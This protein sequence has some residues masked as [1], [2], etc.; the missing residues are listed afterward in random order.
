MSRKK[1]AD[2]SKLR[3][4][5]QENLRVECESTKDL[6]YIDSGNEVQDICTR[7]N[8]VVFARRGCGKTLLLHYSARVL[9]NDIKA[10]YLNCEDF[11][12][13]SFP[14][15]LIEIFDAIF[16]ELLKNLHGWFG[17]KKKLRQIV[18]EII[19]ELSS[20]RET[21]DIS[22]IQVTT[23]TSSEEAKKVD[24]TA[25]YNAKKFGSLE[26]GAQ[27]GANRKEDIEKNFYTKTDKLQ[28]IDLRLPWFKQK[29]R[30]FFEIS[31]NVKFIFL[32]IDDFYHLRQ[33][34]QP[35]VVDYIHRLCKDVPLFFKIATLRHVSVLYSDHKGQPIGAQERHDYQPINIDYTFED[36]QKTK[37]KN[38]QIF[39][40][41]GELAGIKSTEFDTL[42]FK[43]EGFDRLV[44]AGGG[45]PRDTLSLFLE[46]FSNVQQN[47][48]DRIGKD[49]V[50][51]LS[52]AN[53]EHLIQELKN[54]SELIEQEPL[55]K[56]IYVIRTF[57]MEKRTSIFLVQEQTLQQ[58]DAFH[59]VIYRLLD[60]RI[61][62]TAATALTHK[63]REG[64]YQ[65]FLVNIGCYAHLRKLD[66]KIN[67]I[68]LSSPTAK[69][70][71]RSAPILELN[72]FNTQF[73]QAPDNVEQI[74]ITEEN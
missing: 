40:Q 57:C 14:N 63:S 49:D 20:L 21:E 55:V 42:F 23:K 33:E 70:K 31:S 11:K 24:F 67:E 25:G 36:F 3:S 54:D 74:L 62:H 64:T 41:F 65:A 7:Q 48:D 8:H 5:I 47:S 60:Y 17:R 1:S 32:Q 71:M 6:I 22:D 43:G 38:R 28:R 68:D 50:R 59:R 46:V 30:E 44:L 9:N 26:I 15:V 73:K 12:Q 72:Q 37:N 18:K 51:I 69:D 61:I 39:H 13:H 52:K 10:I 53:F 29:I 2:Y 4:I 27:T 66:K 45:V 58:E 16:K 34:D 19:D 35:Y 56:A